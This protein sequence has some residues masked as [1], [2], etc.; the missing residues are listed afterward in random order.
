MSAPVT[1]TAATP[2]ATTTDYEDLIG[3]APAGVDLDELLTKASK[4]IRRYCRWHIAPAIDVTLTVDGSG[5]LDLIL[6]TLKLNS[7]AAVVEDGTA[8]SLAELEWTE[9]GWLRKPAGRWTRKLRG[10]VASIN[11][12][13]D[14]YDDLTELACRV[15]ARAAITP[16]GV[17]REQALT[18]SVQYATSGGVAL[19]SD[20]K[21]DL[22]DLR[23]RARL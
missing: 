20:E 16:T 15:A 6:P 9:M 21:A 13:F 19:M 7:I 2:L 10:V 11:H 1:P 8:L 23:L 14:E 4:A 18:Q 12:G 5:A 3:P 17:V 22:A